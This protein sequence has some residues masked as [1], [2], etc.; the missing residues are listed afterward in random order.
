MRFVASGWGRELWSRWWV[1]LRGWMGGGRGSD[2]ATEPPSPN[3]ICQVIVDALPYPVFCK[4]T[5]GSYLAVNDAYESRFGVQRAQ[6]LGRSL[7]QT[8][9]IDVDWE[10]THQAHL[11]VLRSQAAEQDERFL[12]AIDGE[13]LCR[14][15]RIPVLLPN[16]QMGLLVAIADISG[17]AASKSQD[18]GAGPKLSANWDS[19]LL[20][21]MSHEIRTPMSGLLGTLE[22]LDHPHLSERQRT[23]LRIA[24]EAAHSLLHIIDDVLDFARIEAGKLAIAWEP[25]D[26]RRVIGDVMQARL[27]QAAINGVKI[28]ARVDSGVAKY[29]RGDGERLQQLLEDLLRH[30]FKFTFD[31]DVH[32]EVRVTESAEEWQDIEIGVIGTGNEMSAEHWENPSDP[33][34]E[35]A[36]SIDKSGAADGLELVIVHRLCRLMDLSINHQSEPGQGARVVLHGRFAMT[37]TSEGEDAARVLRPDSDTSSSS[38]VRRILV[39]EDHAIVREVLHRQLETLGRFCDVVADGE[40][41]LAALSARP[42]ALLIT[43]CHMPKMDGF[44]LTR[45]IRASET[46]SR[47]PVIALTANVMADQEKRCVE[48]GMDDMLAKPLRLAALADKLDHWIGRSMPATANISDA[49]PPQTDGSDIAQV[50]ACLSKVFGDGYVALLK[51]YVELAQS[52]LERLNAA[53]RVM[54]IDKLREV[55]HSV[56]GIAAFFGA[57]QLAESASLVESDQPT[58]DM[59]LNARQLESDLSG[60]ALA[61]K[62]SQ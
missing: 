8:R 47:L 6:L 62:Q 61:L 22:L 39:A 19:N 18:S 34:V 9:H 13:R 55:A 40:E 17:L 14:V 20:S 36:R 60:F 2:F 31:G 46:D 50:K 52:E 45:R 53:L 59:L 27:S 24:G 56:R 58:S 21:L 10:Q 43:D 7:L 11:R 51:D 28:D 29:L 49:I 32:I 57:S 48:A 26:L 3:E 4:D 37:G 15:H 42:Y 5:Q 12:P 30:A 16:G 25:F 23:L 33:S 1:G 41:A 35:I 54:D 38:E 44:E